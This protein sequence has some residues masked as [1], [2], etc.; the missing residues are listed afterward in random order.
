MRFAGNRGRDRSRI[1]Y[2]RSIEVSG[3]PEDAYNYAV[4]GRSPV[5]WVMELQ[6][7]DALA[8]RIRLYEAMREAR[9]RLRPGWQ[10]CWIEVYRRTRGN[11]AV[12]KRSHW[13][14]S[15]YLEAARFRHAAC[16]F[17]RS[18]DLHFVVGPAPHEDGPRTFQVGSV[19]NPESVPRRRCEAEPQGWWNA[20]AQPLARGTPAV[21]PSRLPGC[22]PRRA[23]H[24]ACTILWRFVRRDLPMPHLASRVAG[25]LTIGCGLAAGGDDASA[26]STLELLL[27]SPLEY[28]TPGDRC[29]PRICT[30]LLDWI[31]AAESTIDFAIYGARDQT[32]ILEALSAARARG[33]KVRGYVDRDRQGNNY[34]SST[35]EWT[36]RLGVIADDQARESKPTPFAPNPPRCKRPAGFA[37]PLQCLAYDLGNFWLL[38][39]HASREDFTDPSGGGTNKIMHNKFFVVDSKRVWT[40]SANISD[41]GTGGYNANAAIAAESATLALV[42]TQEFDRM[43]RRTRSRDEKPSTGPRPHQVG[44]AIVEPWFSPQDQP[45]RYAVQPLIARATSTIDVSIFFLTHKYVAADLINAHKRG[46][47]VRIIVDAT[48]ATNGYTKHELLRVAGIPLK[49]ENWGGKMHAKAGAIDGEILIL[50]SMNWTSAGDNAND[51]NTLILRSRRLAAQYGDWFER[52]WQSI[53]NRWLARGARPDPESA[54]SGSACADGADNDFDELIDADDPGCGRHPPPLAQLPPY[55]LV[56]KERGTRPPPTHRVHWGTANKE[57]TNSRWTVF[58]R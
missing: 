10:L 7:R 20:Y 4:Y 1:V 57:P 33:V 8:P 29:E 5:E 46:V 50:G 48:A 23:T 6:R 18:R 58:A 25:L 45:M 26:A 51:E 41:S 55:R 12:G 36:R 53:P 34:Y 11:T 21:E 28:A 13:S 16:H 27:Q 3:I 30:R 38:A 14:R 43:T 17:L 44:D 31:N 49:V 22:A 37:G 2:N 42:Y 19:I 24:G 32:L 9:R 40:G 52:L 35:D 47:R 39:E 54:D 15:G 56:A